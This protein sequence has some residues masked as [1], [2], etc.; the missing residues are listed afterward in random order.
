MIEG[1]LELANA[2][3]HIFP[4]QPRGKQP[5][6]K[7]RE[8][9][10]NDTAK[11]ESWWGQWPDANV[12][13]DCGKS[14]LVVVDYDGVEAPDVHTLAVK[15]GRGVHH[16]FA[17]GGDPV[18]NSAS[19][20]ED[21]VDVRGEGGYVLAPPSVHPSGALY[22]WSN[23]YSPAPLPLELRDRMVR[24]P[25][26][27]EKP[28]ATSTVPSEGWGGKILQSEAAIVR[29]TGEGRRNH[30]LFESAL[31]VLSAAKGGHLDVQLARQ[32]LMAA[33]NDAGL[34]PYEANRTLDSAWERASVRNPP[35]RQLPAGVGVRLPDE[36]A[37]AWEPMSLEQLMELPP[38]KWLVPLLIVEGMNWLVGEQKIGKTFLALDA[39]L[40]LARTERVLYF[41]GEGVSGLGV[42]IQ[43]WMS[44]HQANPS[45]LRVFPFVPKLNRPGDPERFLATV[46][47][48]QPQLVVIDTFARAMAGADEN[49]AMEVGR[50]ISMVDEARERTGCSSLI[51]HHPAKNGLGYRGSGAIAGAADL[52]VVLSEDESVPGSLT[53]T[54]DD[55]KDFEE[56]PSRHFQL[57]RHDHSAI[58][59][60]SAMV[61][62]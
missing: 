31:R 51:L 37:D 6:V 62:R 7:W 21:H 58:I 27:R 12:G 60:P 55:V 59:Y 61:Q 47:S 14:G 22:E 9:S 41:A 34:D 11:V 10:T 30:Q 52:L 18:P 25:E 40:T 15:T 26:Q 45:G 38:P 29:T 44:Y 35:E 42:R 53:L 50:F 2:G 17:N 24:K 39:A 1:A 36:P 3:W 46:E 49:S 5:L 28:V 43:S 16:Y 20:L 32:E 33:A 23:F 8:E 13:I 19:M 56:P 4:V 48:L 57:R 54:Y